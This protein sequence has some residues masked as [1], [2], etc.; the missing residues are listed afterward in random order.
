MA[1]LITLQE[2][3]TAEGI[4][5]PKEDARL[6]VLIPSI[7]QLVKTYC[8]NSFVDFYS[9]NKTETFTLEWGTHI[10]QLTES[11]VNAIVSVQEATSY[12]GTLTTL[13]TGA[14]EYALNKA[15]DCI[16]RTTTG[17]YKNWPVGVETVKVVYTAGYSAVPADLK[18]AVLDLITYYLKDEHKARQS[19]A[20]ASIQ[21]QTSSSQRDNVS[22]PDHIK[23]V[24]DLYKN[25]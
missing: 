20:G 22:F 18:L 6:N 1:D 23:R 9:T 12:G 13:T 24:L 16:Y 5:Q 14:Q 2:Y 19:I 17:G 10:V 7:S 8:G 15:T 3:K 21:N 11:P 25:F 4:T